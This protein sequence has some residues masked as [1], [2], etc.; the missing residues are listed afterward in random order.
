MRHRLG[1]TKFCIYALRINFRS[2][3]IVPSQEGRFSLPNPHH[4]AG[5]S[6]YMREDSKN[7]KLTWIMIWSTSK[8]TANAAE[9]SSLSQKTHFATSFHQTF[10]DLFSSRTLGK[11]AATISLIRIMINREASECHAKVIKKQVSATQKKKICTPWTV[12]PVCQA[13]HGLKQPVNKNSE[14]PDIPEAILAY[15][16]QPRRAQAS[17]VEF[18][19]S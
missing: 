18:L 3:I 12:I 4:R 7:A 14:N 9:E 11:L 19:R 2:S 8:S 10:S 13:T 16:L 6:E 1:D 5:D 17:N 15:Q